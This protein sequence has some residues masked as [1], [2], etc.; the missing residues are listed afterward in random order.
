MLLWTRKIEFPE[1]L[2]SC[3]TLYMIN[4]TAD[5][6]QASAMAEIVHIK[7]EIIINKSIISVKKQHTC[8]S[9]PYKFKETCIYNSTFM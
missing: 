8:F 9:P 1:H 4:I 6:T 5:S 3:L 7:A 2:V